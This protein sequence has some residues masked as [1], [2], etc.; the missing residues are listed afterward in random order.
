VRWLRCCRRRP[1]EPAPILPASFDE[2]DP[3]I[4]GEA[5][6]AIDGGTLGG[7]PS[8]VLDLGSIEDGRW[9]VLREGALPPSEVEGLLGRRSD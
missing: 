6:L 8:T 5:H 4:L 2:V 1:T 3:E 9:R 7:A